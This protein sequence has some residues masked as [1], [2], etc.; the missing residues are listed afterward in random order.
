MYFPFFYPTNLIKPNL[1]LKAAQS[2]INNFLLTNVARINE[3]LREVRGA[4][5]ARDVPRPGKGVYNS[6]YILGKKLNL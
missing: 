2:R 4:L 1:F 3:E 6:I 5:A